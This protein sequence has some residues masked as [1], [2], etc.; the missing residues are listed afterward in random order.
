MK[1]QKT[2]NLFFQK[3]SNSLFLNWTHKKIIKMKLKLHTRKNCHFNK[4]QM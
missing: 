4:L 2:H 3:T 1:F